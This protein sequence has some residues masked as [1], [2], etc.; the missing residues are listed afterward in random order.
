MLDGL[1][2]D[3]YQAILLLAEK[4][5]ILL[6]WGNVSA[7]D[8]QSGHIVIKPG[9]ISYREIK[10]QD[11]V[12]CDLGGKVLEGKMEPSSDLFTYLEIYNAYP[13]ITSIIHIHSKWATVFAQTGS[14][15]PNLGT[16]HV[17]RFKE[18]IPITRVMTP[19]EVKKDYYRNTGRVILETQRGREPMDT[20]AAL[21]RSHAAFVWGD[22]LKGAVE[23]AV[24]LEF[25]ADMA[26]HTLMLDTDAEMSQYLKE[27]H[28]IRKKDR[29]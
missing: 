7:R 27:V 20:P 28:S 21:V 15:I 22:S 5:L 3:T 2:I 24:A 9:G 13:A 1:K 10:P 18:D 25:V 11:M 26:Y 6:K 16:T 14:S 19:Y 17:D 12:V 23:S 4:G 29:S 8:P